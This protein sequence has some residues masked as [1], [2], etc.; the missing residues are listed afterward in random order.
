MT[1]THTPTDR[2]TER[3]PSHLYIA[4]AGEVHVGV[5]A[6]VLRRARRA[7]QE[8]HGQHEVLRLEGPAEVPFLVQGPQRVLD[9]FLIET[10]IE[11]GG[12]I[13]TK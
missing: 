9:E 4:V 13:V 3:L 7:L 8:V 1:H 10:H 12:G 2:E 5:V 11:K 6:L